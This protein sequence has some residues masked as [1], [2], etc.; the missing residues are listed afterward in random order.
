M[1]RLALVV[2]RT[3]RG[4]GRYRWLLVVPA[5]LVLVLT[6]RVVSTDP[7]GYG[8]PFWPFANGSDRVEYLVM[9][10]VT[11]IARALPRLDAVPSAVAAE[12][13][14]VLDARVDAGSMWMRV[15]LDVP[16]GSRC[17]EVT[18]LGD[19]GVQVNSRRV[20]C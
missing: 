14:E 18:V 10:Q 6:A 20:D 2:R 5:V 16:D 13:V 3:D 15:R 4:R 17:R 12:G 9:S 1:Q 19:T 8:V 7:V 11:S